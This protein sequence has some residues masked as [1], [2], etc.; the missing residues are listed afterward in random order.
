MQL[1][2]GTY[3][4]ESNGVLI[5]QRQEILWTNGGEPYAR[6][7]TI[8]VEGFLSGSGSSDLSGE[9]S[10]LEDALIAARNNGKQVDL[11]FYQ[12]GGTSSATALTKQTSITGVKILNFE[13]P[14]TRGPDYA[15]ERA[16]KF[17]AEAEYGLAGSA[18]LLIDFQETVTITPPGP[19]F[20]MRPSVNT[21]SQK[22]LLHP[23]FHCTATQQGSATGY[24][25]RPLT[26]PPL[27]PFAL[28]KPGTFT[29]NSPMRRRHGNHQDWSITWAYEF[30][31]TG[32]LVGVP[33]LFL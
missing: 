15:T 17:T 33:H 31:H 2:L 19:V 18:N 9:Q 6:V 16:F 7:H 14:S 10:D 24:R 26:P 30:A 1:K 5:G 21:I 3:E 11:I 20:I 12:D 13:F 29:E 22:Q 23:Q 27:W 8:T 32:P 28:M 25:H 4:F